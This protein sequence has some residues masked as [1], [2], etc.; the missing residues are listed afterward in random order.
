MKSLNAP[1]A[2]E[3][4]ALTTSDAIIE[5][6][7]RVGERH[8]ISELNW[9]EEYPYKPLTSFTI[10]HTDTAIYIDFFTRCNYLRA[11]HY[12]N[13]SRVCE[14]SCVEF[15]VSPTSDNHYFNFEFN[16][17]GTIHASRRTSRHDSSPLS[18]EE[19]NS[20]RRYPSCGT[21]PFKEMEGMFSWNL[22][23]VIPLKLIGVE[24]KGEPI[25]MTANFYKCAD[26]TSAA[27]YLTW[28]PIDSPK[29]DYHRPEFFGKMT[30]L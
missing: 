24:Y 4:D 27:H 1:Y 19:L 6:L 9:P 25:S 3:L 20:V 26:R 13:Q 16:C 10:A 7:D 11:E 28:N 17:I 2:P 15:F 21:R 5:T 8:R 18:D 12:K 22:L 23:V 14:D 30:L 29:P